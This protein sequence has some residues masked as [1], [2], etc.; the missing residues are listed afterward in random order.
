MLTEKLR[1]KQAIENKEPKVRVRQFFDEYEE[2][3]LKLH[4]SF[5]NPIFSSQHGNSYRGTESNP[6]WAQNIS[7]FHII[8]TAIFDA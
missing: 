6:K 8:C 3:Y 4:L 2:A 5:R 1:L 7:E